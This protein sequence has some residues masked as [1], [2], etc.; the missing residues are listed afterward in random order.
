MAL[1][2]D[3]F[4]MREV[5]TERIFSCPIC[6]GELVQKSKARLM[7]VG[8]CMMASVGIAFFVSWFWAPGIILGITGIYLVVW[9]T[10]GKARWCRNCKKFSVRSDH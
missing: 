1:K 2:R 3:S 7:L 6:G 8:L 9:A 10:L 5:I 4:S